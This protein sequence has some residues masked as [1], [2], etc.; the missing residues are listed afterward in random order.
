M[1]KNPASVET[2]KVPFL[3]SGSI[4]LNWCR[5]S[6]CKGIISSELSLSQLRSGHAKTITT[7]PR[8]N[9]WLGWWFRFLEM[10]Y[11]SKHQ[12]ACEISTITSGI[13]NSAIA[14]SPTSTINKPLTEITRCAPGIAQHPLAPHDEAVQNVAEQHQRTKWSGPRELGKSTCMWTRCLEKN[15]HIILE[16]RIESRIRFQVFVEICVVF[17]SFFFKVQQT[18]WRIGAGFCMLFVRKGLTLKDL[19]GTDSLRTVVQG[20]NHGNPESLTYFHGEDLV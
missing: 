14:N 18:F 2:R 13:K 3:Q 17:W 8:L 7:R 5:I 12:S 1:E 15:T 10:F 19:F 9:E 4:Y 11:A 16:S 6:F 20:R